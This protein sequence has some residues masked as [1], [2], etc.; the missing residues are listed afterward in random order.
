MKLLWFVLIMGLG[1][2]AMAS[3]MLKELRALPEGAPLEK[4]L[5]RRRA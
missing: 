3:Y 5:L 1:N 2:I 4:L